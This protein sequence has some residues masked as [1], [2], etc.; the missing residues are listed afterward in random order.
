[1]IIEV[2]WLSNRDLQARIRTGC[3]KHR[4]VEVKLLV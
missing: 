2:E 1:M 4:G 3:L